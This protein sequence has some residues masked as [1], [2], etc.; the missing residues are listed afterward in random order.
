MAS[1]PIPEPEQIEGAERRLSYEEGWALL[2][3]L[4]GSMA[5]WFPDEGGASA[6]FLR[7]REEWGD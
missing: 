3:E 6:V 2:W 5:G 1:Q 4:E 7:E